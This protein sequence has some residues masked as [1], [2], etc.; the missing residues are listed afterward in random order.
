MKAV[1]KLAAKPGHMALIDMPEPARTQGDALI[2]IAAGGICGTD[3]AIWHWHQAVVSQYAPTFPLIVGH[4]FAGRVIEPGPRDRAK[5]GD[6]VAVNPQI[7]CGRCYYCGLGRPTLCDDRRLMGGR[8]NGGW[9]ERVAVPEA[10]LYPLPA[11]TDPAVAPLL[12]PLSVATHAVVERVPPRQGDVVVIIGAGP[13]GLLTL[14][15][16]KQA[17]VGA[18]LMTGVSADAERLALARTMGAV[19]V[20]VTV[21]DPVIALRRLQKDGADVVY[22]TSGNAAV[23]DQALGLARKSGRVCLIGL[24]HGSSTVA[25]VP[26]VLKELEV[27][28][29]R[30]YNDTTWRLMMRALPAVE[31][32]VLRLITHRLEFEQFEE[33][34][35]LVEARAGTKIILTPGKVQPKA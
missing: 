1:A 28:G 7:A 8:I 31:A 9:T 35:G 26:I 12:E 2:E 19:T 29:S 16:A 13:I 18:I 27:I 24:C 32:D 10:N 33:A 23:I 15:M 4:V 3:V 30:G 21:D 11:G 5:V 34:I 6:V 20:D 22:E 25:S 14:V 17:G